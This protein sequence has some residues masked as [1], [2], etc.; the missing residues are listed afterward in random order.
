MK[1]R[2]HPTLQVSQRREEEN[3]TKMPPNPAGVAEKRGREGR[4]I[5]SEIAVGCPKKEESTREEG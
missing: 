1:K 3:E 5:V 4:E 2:F